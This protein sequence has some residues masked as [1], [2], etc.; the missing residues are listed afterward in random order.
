VFLLVSWNNLRAVDQL[1][2][3]LRI[4]SV[5]VY[6][7]PDRNVAHFLENRIVN[8]GTIWTEPRKCEGR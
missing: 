7:L 6:L 2:D 4:L 8:I 3:L 5:P 1:M